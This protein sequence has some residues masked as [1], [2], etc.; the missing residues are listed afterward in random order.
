M[1][2]I[3]RANCRY[4]AFFCEENIWW[5]ARELIDRGTPANSLEV[6]FFS[7]PTRSVLLLNQ[8]GVE[9]G[10]P[11]IWD[12]H[13]VLRAIRPGLDRIFDLD[14]RLEFP[15]STIDYLAASFPKQSGLPGI[16]RAWVRSAPASGF[17]QRF[18]SDRS[19]M[20]GRLD[21][22]DFPDY[23]PIR[24]SSPA[25]AICLPDYWDMTKSLPDGSR[26]QLLSTLLPQLA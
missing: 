16:Y 9:A 15:S 13:V 14:T 11:L 4:T 17:L 24:A 2:T 21:P 10:L 1:Q 23:P 18:Q 3:A 5:L 20:T 8:Q 19:H 7:N 26:V 12:Y 6:L 22:S 25:E